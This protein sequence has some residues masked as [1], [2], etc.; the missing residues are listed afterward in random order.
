MVGFFCAAAGGAGRSRA[1]CSDEGGSR[2]PDAD[3]QEAEPVSVKE[4]LAMYQ[5][6]VSSKETSASSSAA[7]SYLICNLS[8]MVLR[9]LKVNSAPKKRI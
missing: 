5:A 9:N 3:E 1:G 8:R 2:A 7:V 4:R 6:A